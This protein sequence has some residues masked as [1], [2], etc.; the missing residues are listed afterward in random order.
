MNLQYIPDVLLFSSQKKSLYQ[1]TSAEMPFA[2]DFS[3]KEE[4]N[5]DL[6]KR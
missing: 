3:G 6:K 1:R 4:K 2:I 5:C